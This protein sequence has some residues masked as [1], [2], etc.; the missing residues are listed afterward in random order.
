MALLVRRVENEPLLALLAEDKLPAIGN[1]VGA[2]RARE[3]FVQNC[4]ST[5]HGSC[6]SAA[7]RF[8]G[9]FAL[10]HTKMK[11]FVLALGLHMT[12]M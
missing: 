8:I 1:V 12:F 4:P 5:V 2:A 6:S 3:A 7:R 11:V 10:S 9:E